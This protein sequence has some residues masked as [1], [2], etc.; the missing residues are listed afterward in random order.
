MVHVAPGAGDAAAAK[1]WKNE[2]AVS[3]KVTEE[4]RDFPDSEFIARP[5][6]EGHTLLLTGLTLSCKGMVHTKHIPIP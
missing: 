2:R 6:H 4:Y 3:F 1:M 5:G